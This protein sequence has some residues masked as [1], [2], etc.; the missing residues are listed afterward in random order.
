MKK[1]SVIAPSNIAF[2]KFWGR[3]DDKL[4]L[5]MNSSISM[6]L[7]NCFTITTIE[8]SK[9]YTE[10]IVEIRSYKE[11]KYKKLV[12][13]DIKDQNIFDQIER[14]RKLSGIKEK[15]YIRSQNSFPAN[16]GIA[17]SASGF[18]ALTSAL[19]L[20]YKQEHLFNNKKELSKLVRLCGSGSAAR[21]VYGGIVELKTGRT[22]D[23]SYAVQLYNSEY[24]DLVDIVCII[25]SS[26]KKVSSSKG[27]LKSHSSEFEKARQVGLR[28]RLKQIKQAIKNKEL[29]RLGELIEADALSMHAVMMTQTPSLLYWEPGTI[30]VMKQ[31]IDL[32]GKDILGYFTIDAGA[33][34]H[35]IT[36]SKNLEKLLPYLKKNEYVKDMIVNRP[37]KDVYIT[38]EHLF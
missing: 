3:R 20:V 22:H 6:S 36:D 31:V 25:D 15:V 18:S 23:E 1:I 30:S 5:P 35:V 4:C 14:I 33:N 32:R 27:H 13:S 37:G 7:N 19:L 29:E 24:W 16:S 10:D 26:S 11:E 17:S 38:S 8:R 2:I 34:V 9:K 28:N 21:S 12:V